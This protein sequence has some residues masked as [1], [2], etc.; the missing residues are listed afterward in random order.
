MRRILRRL[1]RKILKLG[2]ESLRKAAVRVHFSRFRKVAIW[3]FW[4]EEIIYW[5]GVFIKV[6]P[7]DMNGYFLYF[8]GD[9]SEIEV[10]K[11]IERCKQASVF[12]D[13]GANI[14][15]M[16]LVAA[17]ACPKLEVFAFE[18]DHKIAAQFRANLKLNP[19]LATRVHLIEKAVSDI[20]GSL[21]FQPTPD[22]GHIGLGR[23]ALDGL[24]HPTLGY[25]V[26]SVRL[27]TFFAAIGK[28]PDIVKIDVEGAEIHVLEGMKELFC[29]GLPLAIFVE[30]HA[31]FLGD[32]SL[33]F[34]SKVK[35]ILENAGY[36]LFYL[37][38]NNWKSWE[39][40]KER[41]E[42]LHFHILALREHKY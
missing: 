17:M 12:A 27:D 7:G 33:I 29:K 34:S 1:I 6:N 39:L 11:I 3:L 41:S 37:K 5:K 21:L 9:Y 32:N 15:Q 35:E 18:A 25:K 26:S 10:N 22:I 38:G 2:P 42:W 20:N 30:V 23:L 19:D 14:G 16:S 13:V 40:S 28:C 31:T 36:N 8:F 24:R 4:G